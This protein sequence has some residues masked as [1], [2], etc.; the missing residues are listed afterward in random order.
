MN[1]IKVKVNFKKGTCDVTGI[2]LVTGDYNSTI[3]KLTMSD[4]S[5]TNIFNMKNPSDDLVLSTEIVNGE[6]PLYR[7]TEEGIKESILAEKGNYT[8]EIAK[9]GG[10]SKLT[11]AYGKIPVRKAQVNIDGELVEPY[12]PVFDG[13]MS[14][15][16]ALINQANN[17]NINVEKEGNVTTLTITDKT[18]KEK[19]IRI[20]DGEIGPQG[21]QGPR[22]PQGERGPQG[23][24]G[25][26]GIQGIQGEPGPS[27]SLSIGNVTKGEVPSASITGESPNQVLNLTLPKGDKGDMG[28]RG[29]QGLKGETGP[30]N[31]LTIGTVTK[32]DTPSATIT[33]ESPNQVLNLVLPKGDP[34]EQGIQGE[35]GVSGVWVG[36]NEP[37]GDYNVW[38]DENGEVS[39]IPTKLS[40]L[41]NDT[42]FITNADIIKTGITDPN[43]ETVGNFVGQIYC[44]TR[45]DTA[46][47][48]VSITKIDGE[49]YYNWTKLVRGNDRV[50]SLSS[51]STDEQYPSAKCVYDLIGNVETELGGV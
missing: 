11:S 46:Y 34:G 43:T 49:T 29:Y 15:L 41:T 24:Q 3:I 10:D 30:A 21:S 2:K 26:Q 9:Y 14:Q 17:L 47:Q 12:L 19:V 50:T 16:S 1:T 33:G 25:E 42:G 18:G 44:N 38:I 22:G 7:E 23:I 32:S 37:T 48:L 36:E 31:T 35:Q 40:E 8:F 6:V 13:L 39:T 28:P 27:N 51:S 20:L 45:K 4:V 5:G